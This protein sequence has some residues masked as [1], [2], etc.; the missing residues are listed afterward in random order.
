[1]VQIAISLL[2]LVV[3]PVITAMQTS[4]DGTISLSIKKSRATIR[5]STKTILSVDAARL[6]KFKGTA[7][8]STTFT[9]G[10]A[11]ATNLVDL[12]TVAVKVGSQTFPQMVVDTGSS[13]IWVGGETKF[14][15]GSTGESTG[16]TVTVNYGSSSIFG[17]EYTDVVSSMIK[18]R[19]II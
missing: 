15:S 18:K 16:K 3:I 17:T 6:K 13:I 5:P 4:K 1:M 12:Y 7:T 2:L 11:I 14:V 8:A 9:T 10:V 19:V